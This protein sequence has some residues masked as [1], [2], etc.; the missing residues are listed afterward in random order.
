M[1][2]P[3]LGCSAT[4]HH[5]DMALYCK[6]HTCMHMQARVRAR[7]HTL[8]LLYRFGLS[9]FQISCSCNFVL[10]SIKKI[11]FVKV[12][13]FLKMYYHVSFQ[14]SIL[15]GAIVAPTWLQKIKS[16]SLGWVGSSNV[17][18][19]I[20]NSNKIYPSVLKLKPVE[21]CDQPYTHINFEHTVWSMRNNTWH[22]TISVKWRSKGFTWR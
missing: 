13:Y 18:T 22:L 21:R 19:F 11:N 12:A 4:H 9:P 5:H 2:R 7:T 10:H 15:S 6:W 17:I 8:T 16:G 1:P 14:N 20:P 3:G